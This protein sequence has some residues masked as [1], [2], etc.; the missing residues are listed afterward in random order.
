MVVSDIQEDACQRWDL[1]SV[2]SGGA[3]GDIQQTRP[4]VSNV[5]GK[6][7]DCGADSGAFISCNFRI[8]PIQLL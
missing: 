5:A 8:R 6:P 3:V 4:S 1:A 2:F 7:E